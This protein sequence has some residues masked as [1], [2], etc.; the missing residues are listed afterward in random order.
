MPFLNDE[1]MGRI[2]PHMH[3]LKKFTLIG[4]TRI[5][6]TGVFHLL[7]AAPG[8]EELVLDAPPHSVS[9]A[10]VHEAYSQG[11]VDLSAAPDLERLHTF[12]LS[13]APQKTDP[14]H[15]TRSVVLEPA[16][17][18][19]LRRTAS[20]RALELTI[21]ASR[22]GIQRQHLLPR[23]SLD[24]LMAQVDYR[25]L[26]RLAL[27]NI[28]VS[29][30]VLTAVLENTALVELYIS[31]AGHETLTECDALL[32]APLQVLHANAPAQVGPTRTHLGLLAASMPL[33][34]EIGSLNRVYEVHRRWLGEER[35][36]ELVRWS[37]VHTPRYFQVWRP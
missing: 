18:P 6:R 36:V 33:V 21:S 29:A 28:V 14:R 23:H 34:E 30:E 13:F 27:L 7:D 22:D 25:A 32:R 12:S 17:L 19:V 3:L 1:W 35:V 20:L 2:A 9:S 4:N 37:Q 5:T 8:L 31:V 24:A 11:L 26:S 16:D 10:T 15:P